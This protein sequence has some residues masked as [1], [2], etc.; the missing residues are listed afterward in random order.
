M[1]SFKSFLKSL[2]RKA[3]GF[4]RGLNGK[5]AAGA[6]SAALSKFHPS[7]GMAGKVMEQDI[8]ETINKGL[9]TAEDYLKP[10]KPRVMTEQEKYLLRRIN[11]V[12][13]QGISPQQLQA[14]ILADIRK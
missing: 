2:G 3:I 1:K 12:N 7:A 10:D 13:G 14:N 4:V 11:P 9:D 5:R 8:A 6:I